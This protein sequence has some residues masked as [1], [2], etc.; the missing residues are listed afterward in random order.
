MLLY[1]SSLEHSWDDEQLSL[2]LEANNSIFNFNFTVA[3]SEVPHVSQ[4]MAAQ[5]LF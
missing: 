1:S 2:I 3:Y 5:N 4:A